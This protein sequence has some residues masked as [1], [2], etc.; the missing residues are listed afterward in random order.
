MLHKKW[1]F[2]R[3]N[4]VHTTVGEL[5]GSE[6]YILNAEIPGREMPIEL[7]VVFHSR[8]D[9]SRDIMDHVFKI[10]TRVAETKSHVDF[11][12]LIFAMLNATPMNRGSALVAKIYSMAVYAYVFGT[13]MPSMPDGFDVFAMLEPNFETFDQRY[14]SVFFPSSNEM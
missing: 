13:P 1:I 8:P 2:Q 6:L 9:D 4:Y 12:R 3:R 7:L 5:P 11:M 10:T 14:R